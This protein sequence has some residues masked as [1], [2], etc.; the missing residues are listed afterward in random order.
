[1][2]LGSLYEL[3]I[4]VAFMVL[5]AKLFASDSLLTLRP[6]NLLSRKR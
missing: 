4:F 2:V 3:A 5:A 6:G 1:V